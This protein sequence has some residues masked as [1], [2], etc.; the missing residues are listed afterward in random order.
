MDGRSDGGLSSDFYFIL[1]IFLVHLSLSRS[2]KCMRS[3]FLC[4]RLGFNHCIM[5]GRDISPFTKGR[6][7]SLRHDVG[8]SYQDIAAVTTVSLSAVTKY[9]QRNLADPLPHP[10]RRSNCRRPRKTNV[11]TDRQIVRISQQNP[12]RGTRQISADLAGVQ[13][14]SYRTVGRRLNQAGLHSFSP[15]VKPFLSENHKILRLRWAQLHQHLNWS[16]VIF[17]DESKFEIAHRRQQFVR[18]KKGERYRDINI[19]TT[20]NRATAHCM[21]WGAFCH[22]GATQLVH[23]NG[24]LNSE[25]YCEILNNHFLPFYYNIN[26]QINI[27][28]FQHDNAPIHTSQFTNTWLQQNDIVVL[29]WPALSPDCNLVE[30]MWGL[31]KQQLLLLP[32][33]PANSDELFTACQRLWDTL[34]SDNHYRRKLIESMPRRCTALIAAQGGH[35]KY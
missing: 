19:T 18:R 7:Y 3:L 4:C 9:C 27:E 32:Q 1:S 16:Q 14:I 13:P 25:G 10:K 20:G 35:M 34:A 6:I 11:R 28:Y 2:L 21:V 17:S 31:M 29:P 24:R 8:W 22:D 15:A 30:N 33:Q 26:N 12:F 5:R 23:V